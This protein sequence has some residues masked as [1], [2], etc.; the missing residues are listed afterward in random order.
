MT[1]TAAE[2]AGRGART[3]SLFRD[4]N[5]RVKDIN[6]AFSVVVPLGDWICE[7]FRQDCSERIP[8]TLDE[9][10]QTRAAPVRFA[11]APSDHHVDFLIEDV[12][13]RNE[14]YWLVE[15]TG[16]AAELAQ[17]VDPRRAA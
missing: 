15:K 13:D 6:E 3:Q 11:V 14:R 17:R 12:V 7:C 2:H 4:I 8:L 9:Y 16:L 10:E 5:E 1:E